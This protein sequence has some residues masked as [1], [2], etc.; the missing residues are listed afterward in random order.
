MLTPTNRP[1]TTWYLWT[2]TR[3]ESVDQ[4][5]AETRRDR[6]P[7]QAVVAIASISMSTPF[8]NSA[9]PTALR[10]GGSPPKKLS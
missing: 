4:S 2:G 8:G 5:P 9:T 10:A 1:T 7:H 6:G 3:T